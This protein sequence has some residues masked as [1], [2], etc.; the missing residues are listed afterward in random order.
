[1][2]C[3]SSVYFV[4]LANIKI[5]YANLDMISIQFNFTTIAYVGSLEETQSQDRHIFIARNLLGE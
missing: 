4:I 2:G 5:P 3:V 1:M